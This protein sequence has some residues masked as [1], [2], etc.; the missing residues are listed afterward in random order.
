MKIAGSLGVPCTKQ[1]ELENLH[2]IAELIETMGFPM[3]LKPPGSRND[4]NLPSFPLKFLVAKNE[5][6]LHGYL[7]KYCQDGVYPMFQERAHGEV[8]NYNCFVDQ[9]KLLAVH[10]HQ[11]TLR[12]NGVGVLRKVVPINPEIVTYIKKMMEALK[13]NGIANFS[14]FVSEDHKKYGTWKPI[15]VFGLP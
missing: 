14:F 8:H 4:P 2:Q 7:Q 5:A 9:G 13:W 1:F 3:V 15:A 11:S 10:E 12:L 6:Q